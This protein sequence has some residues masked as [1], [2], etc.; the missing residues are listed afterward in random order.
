[1]QATGLQYL[2]WLA[3]FTG[4]AV[5]QAAGLPYLDR[6]A[7]GDGDGI[8]VYFNSTVAGEC[9]HHALGCCHLAWGCLRHAWGCWLVSW[10]EGVVVVA[11]WDEETLGEG[12]GEDGGGAFLLTVVAAI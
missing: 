6:L 1:M 2:D 5:V 7:L 9:C 12:L 8:A 11:G 4:I 10:W 3:A